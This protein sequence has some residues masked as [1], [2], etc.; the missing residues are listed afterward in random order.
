VYAELPAFAQR[1]AMLAGML[2]LFGVPGRKHCLFARP[3]C[4]H[5][6]QQRPSHVTTL[7]TVTQTVFKCCC[8]SH[9]IHTEAF[10]MYKSVA[11]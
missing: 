4:T 5:G 7:D 11:A 10:K 2:E 9:K 6:E 1:I 3:V 8:C